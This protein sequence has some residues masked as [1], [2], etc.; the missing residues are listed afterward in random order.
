MNKLTES[1]L[2]TVIAIVELLKDIDNKAVDRIQDLYLLAKN[3]P[4]QYE[5]GAMSLSAKVKKYKK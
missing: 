4:N 3:S 1:E 2:N 5:L